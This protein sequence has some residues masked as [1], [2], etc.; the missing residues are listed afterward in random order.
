MATDATIYCGDD[1]V[2][3]YDLVRVMTF[4]AARESEIKSVLR[5]SKQFRLC[6]YLCLREPMN[7]TDSETAAHRLDN[8][9][10]Y[11]A[12]QLMHVKDSLFT[13]ENG[14]IMEKLKSLEEVV[15]A[16]STFNG[17]DPRDVIYAVVALS[18]DVQAAGAENS[19]S[20]IS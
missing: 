18:N 3:W 14:E 6:R 10:E 1:Q 20:H 12:Y 4:F 19:V 7:L 8:F 13:I 9:K 11:S 17:Y 5:S 16:L 15:T 2:H